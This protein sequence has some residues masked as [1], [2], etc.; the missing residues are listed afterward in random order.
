MT[1]NE[2]EIGL[3]EKPAEQ[4]YEGMI[5]AI[6]VKAA[7]IEPFTNFL[8]R[9]GVLRKVIIEQTVGMSEGELGELIESAKELQSRFP[10]EGEEGEGRFSKFFRV[11]V[12]NSCEMFITELEKIVSPRK[13]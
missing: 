10:E 12:R 13:C 2:M 11:T 6:L 5:K 8:S 9:E 1:E 4:E 3:G 7:L